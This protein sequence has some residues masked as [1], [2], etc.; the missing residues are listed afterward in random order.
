[1][2]TDAAAVT[3]AASNDPRMVVAVAPGGPAQA[4]D[5]DGFARDVFSAIPNLKDVR[6]VSSEPLRMGMQ[7]GHQIMAT[8]KDN[9]TG[10]DVTIVQWLR[11]G[12]GAYMQMVGV[13]PTD[14]MAAGLYALP[15]SAR[16]HRSA[17]AICAR[18]EIELHQ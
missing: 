10:T 6:I 5:R 16:R 2:L 18:C 17:L 7:Q 13:A 9:A 14:S 11:F 1:M 8:G 4:G 15:R 3:T 12:N